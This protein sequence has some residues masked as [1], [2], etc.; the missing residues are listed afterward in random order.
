MVELGLLCSSNRVLSD[1]SASQVLF[2]F[3][4]TAFRDT[5]AETGVIELDKVIISVDS[6]MVSRQTSAHALYVHLI[7]LDDIA[8]YMLYVVR[9]Q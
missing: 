4:I 5:T 3:P 6:L 9:C 2:N 7:T 8:T 1:L